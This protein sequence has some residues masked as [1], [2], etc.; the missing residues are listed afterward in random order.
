MSILCAYFKGY[1]RNITGDAPVRVRSS[2]PSVPNVFHLWF[3][4]YL[5][6]YTLAL[7]VRLAQAPRLLRALTP[8]RM[9]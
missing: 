5:W 3:V 6:I 1:R 2:C 9:I 7:V 4:A 8:D